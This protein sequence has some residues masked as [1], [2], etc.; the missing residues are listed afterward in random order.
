[1]K[2]QFLQFKTG[3]LSKSWLN[4]ELLM[5]ILQLFAEL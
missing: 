2:T 4:G 3:D 1:M 5:R